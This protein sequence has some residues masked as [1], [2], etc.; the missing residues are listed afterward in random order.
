MDINPNYHSLPRKHVVLETAHDVAGRKV[1]ADDK[2][3]P[4]TPERLAHAHL[5]AAFPHDLRKVTRPCKE[6]NK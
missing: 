4:V 6:G 5:L 3:A 2:D 1:V